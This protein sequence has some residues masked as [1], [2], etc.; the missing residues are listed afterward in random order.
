MTARVA[1][2]LDAERRTEAVSPG[3]TVP[4]LD[5]KVD[6]AGDT[7]TADH[8]DSS[9]VDAPP[10]AGDNALIVEQAGEGNVAVSSY[11]DPKNAGTALPGERRTYARDVDGTVVA[12]IYSQRSGEVR[13]RSIKA[14]SKINLNGVEIDQ[15]GNMTVPGEVTAKAATP[16]TAVKLSTHLHPTGVGPSGAPTPGT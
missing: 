11:H 6:I 1:E 9:G 16:A 4:T 10:L 8:F 13:I 7:T 12:E 2:V 3:V 5:V 15:D 14:G